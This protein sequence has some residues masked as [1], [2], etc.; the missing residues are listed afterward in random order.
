MKSQ[1]RREII[2]SSLRYAVLGVV[3][4]FS[5]LE[6]IKR[7]RFVKEGKCVSKGICSQCGLYDD[8]R[9]PQALSRKQVVNGKN[10]SNEKS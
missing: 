10:N 4:L 7:R 9:L 3:G 5:G 6:L 1:N 8:C 2:K